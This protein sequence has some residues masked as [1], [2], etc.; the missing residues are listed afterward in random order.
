MRDRK[1]YIER[2][3]EEM[4]KMRETQLKREKK[5]ARCDGMREKQQE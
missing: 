3:M 1:K 4:G 5:I 2:G